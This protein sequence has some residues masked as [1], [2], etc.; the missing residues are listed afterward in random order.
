[1]SLR[2]SPVYKVGLWLLTAACLAGAGYFGYRLYA[3]SSP[4]AKQVQAISAAYNA[5]LEAY[6]QKN[7]N[8]AA[9]RFDEARI[10]SDKTLASVLEEVQKGKATDEQVSLIRA[11]VHWLR[12]RAI[13]DHAFAKS[14]VEGNPIRDSDDTQT[15]ESFRAYGAIRDQKEQLEALT[16]LFEAARGSTEPELLK[17]CIRAFVVQAPIQWNIVEPICRKAVEQNPKDARALYYLARF[18]YEQPYT[19]G[20]SPTELQKDSNRIEKA[21]TLLASAKQA[22]SL[23]WRTVGLEAAVL[24]WNVETAGARK[25]KPAETQAAEKSVDDLLFERQNG[26]IAQL[27]RGEK[28]TNPGTADINGVKSVLTVGATR[29]AADARKP[30]GS[31]E[32]VR[33]VADSALGLA[34]R[35]IEDPMLV[36]HQADIIATVVEIAEKTQLYQSK[37]DPAAWREFLTQL[38]GVIAKLPEVVKTRPQVRLQLAHIAVLDSDRIA[39]EDPARAR[40]LVERAI[41]QAEDGLKAAEEAKVPETSLYDYHKLIAEWSLFLRKKDGS[42]DAHIKKLRDSTYPR[43]KALGQFL[44][45][46][47]A[48]HQGRLEKARKLL[49]P[50]ANDRSLGEMSVR[51]NMFLVNLSLATGNPSAALGSLRELEPILQKRED[52][53]PEEKAWAG[54]LGQSMDDIVSL[55]VV[56]T[57]SS[58]MQILNRFA[59]ENP[60]KAVPGEL[61]SGQEQSVD[62][63]L[64]KLRAPSRGDLNARMAIARYLAATK[65]RDVAE[66]K[67]AELATDYPESV[68]I[69]RARTELAAAP[70]SASEGPFNPNGVAQADAMIRKFLKDYPADR[71]GK[72]YYAEWLVKTDRA[73]KAI[74]Y[75][76][77]PNTFPGGGDDTVQRVIAGAMYGAGQRDE[78]RKILGSLAP[79]ARI[80]AV[81]IQAAGTKE[82]AEKKIKEAIDRYDNIGLFRVYEGAL[83]LSER[84]YEEAI[85]EFSSALEFTQVTENARKGLLQALLAYGDQDPAK[86]RETAIRLA[87][88]LPDEGGVLIAAAMDALS[89]EE[90]GAPDDRWEQTKTMY[91]AV[92]RWETLANKAG[93]ARPEILLTKALFRMFAGDLT[94][95][96]REATTSL[97]QY[98]NHMPTILLLADLYLSPPVDT[99]RARE[100]YDSAVRENPKHPELPYLDARIKQ[101][102]GDLAGA[103]TVYERLLS[104]ETQLATAFPLLVGVLE[105]E[106]KKTEALAK[107]REWMSKLPGDS[108]ANREV[109]RLYAVNNMKDQAVKAADEFIARAVEDAGKAL[110]KRDPALTKEEAERVL[111]DTRANATLDVVAAFFRAR[112]VA[113]AE[114]RAQQV[115]STH[116][117][118]T[119]A[120]MF[121]ADCARVQNHWDQALST[122]LKV[123]K[124]SPRH[125]VAGNNAAWILSEQK[126]D[127]A[128]ALAIVEDIRKGANGVRPIAAER[129]PAEFLDTIGAIYMKLKDADRMTEMRS[130]FDAAARR[131]PSDPRML[132]YLGHAQAQVGEKSKAL[133]SLDAA[134]KLAGEKNSISP[135]ENKRVVE[136]AE[137]EKK[138]IRG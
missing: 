28:F 44:E 47:Q 31:V 92:N 14:Q 99:A 93:T 118:A 134:I 17:D 102:S 10:L 4:P 111:K 95:A 62:K 69:L 37:S 70:T 52:L 81:L 82:A 54:Q 71:Q 25:L 68:E 13:R 123:L 55:Q 103:A 122:Y 22:G 11:E 30:N 32:K 131:Y 8:E 74:D 76:K 43:V 132:L 105:A 16:S 114:K 64:K 6:K 5:G 90:V 130:L 97:N 3:M 1:M 85:R 86:A 73:Q 51:A 127:P 40:E 96:K 29:A 138:R 20:Q 133:V 121:L 109:I 36:P 80:D 116:P 66:V 78:A 49:Q 104:D 137:A 72:L 46:V 83:L 34:R 48:E 53:S 65:R 124:E 91:A 100:Y 75:L 38:D 27:A 45:A 106:G 107:A 61:I 79:T 35:S 94:G 63:L 21:R 26:A 101:A 136:A 117:K 39:R 57:L 24:N 41:K 129:L 125:F 18:E 126:N 113:E 77:D 67:L 60:G 42:I 88:E 108:R 23:Y 128:A 135:E 33:F 87:A 119:V 98:S 115:L 84:K 56:A 15:G 58:A 50:L 112:D 120:L 7:W 89:L 59:R 19:N 110:A 9:L 2:N 12:A